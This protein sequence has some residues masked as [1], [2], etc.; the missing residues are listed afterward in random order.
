[1]RRLSCLDRHLT[2][3]IV[4]ATLAGVWLGYAFPA[5][6]RVGWLGSAPAG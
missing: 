2:L 6:A 1:M 3:W 4:L 5:A